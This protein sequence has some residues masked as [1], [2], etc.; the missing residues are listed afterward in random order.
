M[1]CVVN[2]VVLANGVWTCPWPGAQAQWRH[3]SGRPL[4]ASLLATHFRTSELLQKGS[5]AEDFGTT[6]GRN[7]KGPVSSTLFTQQTL[8]TIMSTWNF[9]RLLVKLRSLCISFYRVCLVARKRSGSF[10]FPSATLVQP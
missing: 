7:V 4:L 2:C 5:S 6:Y 8:G 3:P 1:I 10:R 9:Y